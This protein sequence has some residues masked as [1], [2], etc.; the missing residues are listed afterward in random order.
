MNELKPEGGASIS[1][2][3]ALKDFALVEAGRLEADAADLEAKAAALR[4]EAKGLR[5]TH[6]A[7]A[8]YFPLDAAKR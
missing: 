1:L 6:A 8:P 7:A 4:H 5:E 2:L 3:L